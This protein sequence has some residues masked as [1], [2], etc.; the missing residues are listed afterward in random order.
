MVTAAT[1]LKDTCSFEEKATTNLYSILKSRDIADKGPSSQ[2]YGF[3]SSHVWMWE[4]DCKESWALKN[5]CFWTV[6]LEKTLESP[7]DCTEIQPLNPKGNPKGLMLKLKLQYFGHL[8][9]RTDSFEKTLMLGKTEGGRRGWQRMR[10]L[11]VI[12]NLMDMSLSK[13]RELVMD[14]EAWHAAVHRVAKSR[15]QLSDWTECNTKQTLLMEFSCLCRVLNKELP[16][17]LLRDSKMDKARILPCRSIKP[18]G[19][20]PKK[21][22][23]NCEK[24]GLEK[25]SGLEGR[26]DSSNHTGWLVISPARSSWLFPDADEEVIHDHNKLK[27]WSYS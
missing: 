27:R 17:L 10:W 15:T 5:W 13:L 7:L 26:A 8:M 9:Q 22:V 2:N 4:L 23:C 16:L 21:W 11:D 6:V 1:K 3:F 14:R 25:G 18:T 24:G 19:L 20:S 12:T